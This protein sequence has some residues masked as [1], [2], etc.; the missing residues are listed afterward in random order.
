MDDELR[1]TRMTPHESG[2]SSGLTRGRAYRETPARISDGEASVQEQTTQ[3][4]PRS[5]GR[6]PYPGAGMTSSSAAGRLL[7]PRLL[8]CEIPGGQVQGG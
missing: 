4:Q 1:G 5:L 3:G 6:A 7:L 8:S 2:E